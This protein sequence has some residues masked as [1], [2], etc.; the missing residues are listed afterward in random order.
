MKLL[1]RFAVLF[2][3]IVAEEADESVFWLLRLMKANVR[4]SVAIEPL[5]AEATELAKI[6]NAAAR[7]ARTRRDAK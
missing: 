2:F 1:S 4:A 3:F 7:T 5:L 6:F